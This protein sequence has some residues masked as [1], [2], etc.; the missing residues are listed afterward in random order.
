MVTFSITHTCSLSWRFISVAKILTL[1]QCAFGVRIIFS[2]TQFSCSFSF[3]PFVYYGELKVHPTFEVSLVYRVYSRTA[4]DAESGDPVLKKK[5]NKI[6]QPPQ[7]C[8][9]FLP[10]VSLYAQLP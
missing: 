2:R 1:F 8:I 5:Y 6:I 7:I 3:S 10:G 4:K 9:A